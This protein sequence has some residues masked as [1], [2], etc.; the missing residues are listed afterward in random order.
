MTNQTVETQGTPRNAAPSPG[1]KDRISVRVA[2]ILDAAT[3]CFAQKGFTGTKLEDISKELGFRKSVV[4]YYFS[5]KEALIHRVQTWAHSRYLSS[6]KEAL[7]PGD[8]T[9]R[10]TDT[11]SSLWQTLQRVKPLTDLNLEIWNAGR[12]DSELKQRAAALQQ[13]ARACIEGSAQGLLGGGAEGLD[14]RAFSSLLMAVLNGLAVAEYLEGDQANAKG[15]YDLFVALLRS[16]V[17][18]PASLEG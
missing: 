4:H 7:S 11:L 9:S 1:S 17:G 15:A 3:K 12:R 18:A 5:S 13:E 2:E 16:R 8:G 14:Q 10:Q 6:M